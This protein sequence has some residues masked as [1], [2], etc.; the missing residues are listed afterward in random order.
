MIPGGLTNSIK[1]QKKT[2]KEILIQEIIQ[3]CAV[4]NISSNGKCPIT[5]EL[6]FSLAAA[7]E[8]ELR[9]IASELNIKTDNLK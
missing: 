3:V 9:K 7:D 5:G 2:N 6:F 4:S 8:S 1:M